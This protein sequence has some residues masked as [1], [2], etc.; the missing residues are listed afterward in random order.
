M[1]QSEFRIFLSAVT[2][3]FGRARDAVAADLRSREL[4]LR[5][6]SD[7]RQEPGSDT[8]LKM[9]HD[10]IRDC[11][12]VVCIIGK[13]SGAMPTPGEAAAFAHMLPDGFA[14]VSYTQWEF[15]FARHYG[16]RLSRY[17]HKDFL[18][19][20][21]YQ[22]EDGY[23]P[24][25]APLDDDPGLQQAFHDYLV[26]TLGANRRYFATAHELRAEIL[27]EPWP[28]K[29]AGKPI[30]LPYPSLGTLFK[31][32][33]AFLQDLHAS[34]TRGLGR[35]AITGSALHGLG[36]IGK[37]RAAVEYAWAHEQDYT[38]LLFVIADTPEALH[39]NLAALA[40][41]L[42]LNL[43]QQ[44]AAEEDVRLAAVLDWL[45]ANPGWLLILDNLDT[46]EAVKAVRAL[47]KSGRSQKR[48]W[49]PVSFGSGRTKAEIDAAL[50]SVWE[51]AD[52]DPP[53]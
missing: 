1:P 37:T 30:A 17:I 9:L 39:R 48:R 14:K 4:M 15:F 49:W 25:P 34:L 6:Q 44:H 31:G 32:R 8:T 7:F 22:P 12:A 16:R 40:G 42:V 21:T 24:G 52:R 45:K 29:P 35:T 23:Q 47:R 26:N 5:V 53:S 27:K 20:N 28:D 33:D 18:A 46:E 3:E 19:G 51:E 10:Y 13:R 11:D 41:P 36:G 50:A 43:P 2:S 38:A